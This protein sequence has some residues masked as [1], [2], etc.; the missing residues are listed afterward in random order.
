MSTSP[1]LGEAMASLRM[2]SRPETTI[3][4]NTSDVDFI[5]GAGYRALL[6]ALVGPD[7]LWDPRVAL[8]VGPAVARLEAAI[9]AASA[10]PPSA[11]DLTR[12]DEPAGAGTRRLSAHEGDLAGADGCFVAVDT[13]DEPSP[14]GG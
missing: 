6:A 2:S 9:A 12:S 5:A 11:R 13:L 3:V 1:R 10:R 14:T 7:G 8:V 4:L